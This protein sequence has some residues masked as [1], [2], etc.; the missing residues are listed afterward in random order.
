M[1]PAVLGRSLVAGVLA[2]SWLAGLVVLAASWLAGL[3][4]LAAS[5]LAGLV[6]LAASWPARLAT[7][8]GGVCSA[9]PSA[10][11]CLIR[12]SRC[13]A[14]VSRTLHALAPR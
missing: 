7:S 3:V 11:C 4:V 10:F 5:W 6:V 14:C 12:A 2:A 8:R 1:W 9:E 13:S